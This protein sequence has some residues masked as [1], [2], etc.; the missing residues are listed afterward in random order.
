MPVF[1]SDLVFTTLY[2]KHCVK[3]FE[4]SESTLD[5]AIERAQQ[6][7][8]YLRHQVQY[9]EAGR[10]TA[11]ELHA[12]NIRSKGK[13]WRQV[14][15]NLTCLCCLRSSPDHA[16][17][18]GHSLCDNCVQMYGHGMVAFEYHYSLAQCVMCHSVSNALARIKPPTCGVRILSID[19]G[20]TRGAVPLE[21]LKLLQQFL[22]PEVFLQ[23][24]FD[25]VMG[26]SSGLSSNSME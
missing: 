20:G 7:R 19:G 25:V 8:R 6:I 17:P 10:A 1:A 16:L 13:Y 11:S 4:R 2:E 22:S 21:Y 12:S 14:T 26:T 18:C 3:A 15:S 24:F 5:A 23:D 9:L